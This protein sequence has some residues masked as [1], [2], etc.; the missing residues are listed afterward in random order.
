[1]ELIV[2]ALALGV[3]VCAAGWVLAR[4]GQVALRV[5]IASAAEKL[6]RARNE[7]ATEREG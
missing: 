3:V 7:L 1:M 5:Q 4:Q 6:Q 2:G